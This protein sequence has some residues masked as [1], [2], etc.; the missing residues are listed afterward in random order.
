MGL[1]D[2]EEER[3]GRRSGGFWRQK[4]ESFGAKVVVGAGAA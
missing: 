4:L 2:G 3:G 1:G